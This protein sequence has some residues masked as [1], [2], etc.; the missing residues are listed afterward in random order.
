MTRRCCSGHFTLMF[1]ALL[2]CY[3]YQAEAQEA[4][5]DDPAKK[6]AKKDD[7]PKKD[8]PKKDEAKKEEKK[9]EAKK[10]EAKKDEAKKE[11]IKE[12]PK[13]EPFV[14]DIPVKEFKGHGDWINALAF[15]GD[16]LYVASASRD[17]TVKVWEV[18]TGKEVASLK[19]SPENVKGVVFLEGS[20]KVASSTGKWNKEKKTW[21]GEIK[22][23]D[24]KAGKQIGSLKGHAETIEGLALSRD[25]KYLASASEDQTV[26]IWDLVAG[27]DIQTLNGLAGMAQAVPYGPSLSR[28]IWDTL[29]GHTGMVQA[30]A[31]TSDGKKLATASADGTVK[32]W[33]AAS[34]NVVATFKVETMVKTTDPKTKKETLTREP[35]RP[36]TCVAF[37]P[38]NKILSAGNLDGVIKI[39]DVDAAK[40]IGE[41]KAHEG[42]WA[43]AYNP[44]GSRLASA[45]W[46]QTIKVWDTKTNQELFTIKAHNGTVTALAFSPSGQSM[47]SG[48]IDGT[49]KI[50]NVAAPPTKGAQ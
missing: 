1:M 42:V 49:V 3:H 35:G 43:L 39:Y 8:I 48:S 14:P 21:E 40:E 4:K 34:G 25:G 5:K 32:I 16:G 31:F 37:S 10:D 26:K 36:F 13:K 19:G 44:D 22:I 15:S 23:W 50:W 27:K 33:D 28:V 20:A 9:V 12:E 11:E 18:A 45:G 30:V 6:E 24:V 47:A 29:K 17:R 2:A 7:V 46:D 38:D 41:L